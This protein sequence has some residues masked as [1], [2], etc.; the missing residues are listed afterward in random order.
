M[1]HFTFLIMVK[2]YIYVV[3]EYFLGCSIDFMDA[4]TIGKK[5]IKLDKNIDKTILRKLYNINHPAVLR[6]EKKDEDNENSGSE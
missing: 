4:K 5:S 2:R 1:L 3:Y 6:I